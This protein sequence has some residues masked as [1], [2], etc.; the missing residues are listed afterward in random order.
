MGPS[1]CLYSVSTTPQMDDYDDIQIEEFSYFDFV[2]EMNENL[3]DDDE[4]KDTKKSF[5]FDSYL[6]SNIDY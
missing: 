1:K 5:N 6:N 2:E 4:V 3:F